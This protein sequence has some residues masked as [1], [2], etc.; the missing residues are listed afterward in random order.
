LDEIIE[1]ASNDKEPIGNLLRKCLILERQ[2][3]NEKFKAWINKELDGYDSKE[4][5]PSYRSFVCIN[6]GHFLGIAGRSLSD[7]PLSF[8]ILDPKD[9]KLVE[10][11]A[12][13]QPAASYET[14]TDKSGDAMLGWPPALTTKYQTKFFRD[15]DLVLN[16]AWQEIPGSVL[17]ALVEQVR[18]RVLR[19]VLELKDNLPEEAENAKQIP[20]A[21]IDMSVVNNIY[22][23]NILLAAHAEHT[24]QVIS[25]HVAVGDYGAL[26]KALNEI[27]IT[28]GGLE[29]LG[30]DLAEDKKDD[31]STIGQRTKGWIENIGQ[32]VGKEGLKV[33]LEIAKQT[34]IKWIMQH[35][36]MTL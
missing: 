16:R 26:S 21:V 23:G 35:T 9:R 27:G 5:L 31:A 17:V 13:A 2:V 28:E 30:K 29:Q 12:L 20:P 25:Q 4:D 32:Y 19:F 33:G 14:R 3:K 11:V 34:A 18:T 7:Q 10:R 6:R 24:A 8:H 1:A 36:G 22:G 15:S